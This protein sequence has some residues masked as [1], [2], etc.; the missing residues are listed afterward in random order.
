MKMSAKQG[1][2]ISA[3][4][5]HPIM[6]RAFVPKLGPGV[7]DC[8]YTT[9]HD[10]P[11]TSRTAVVVK[12][13]ASSLVSV[14]NRVLGNIVMSSREISGAAMQKNMAKARELYTSITVMRTDA[15]ASTADMPMKRCIL[16]GNSGFAVRRYRYAPTP[17]ST[18]KSVTETDMPHNPNTE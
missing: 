4:M 1:A 5:I 12:I 11:N 16:V 7:R 17:A 10:P 3:Y 2:R 6:V 8:R 9:S 14:T 15:A 13:T 18:K